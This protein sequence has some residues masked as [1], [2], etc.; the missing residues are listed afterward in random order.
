MA[1]GALRATE[2]EEKIKELTEIHKE[3]LAYKKLWDKCY[4][5]QEALR[6]QNRTP[7]S[8]MS[9]ALDD[10]ISEL[11]FKRMRLVEGSFGTHLPEPGR[12]KSTEMWQ[13]QS[14]ALSQ[15]IEVIKEEIKRL[16]KLRTTVFHDTMAAVMVTPIAS[17]GC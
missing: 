13:T 4:R 9:R 5:F 1:A 6:A 14:R 10:L 17:P 8:L 15:I 2:A 11:L 7:S 12:G 16:N 3:F